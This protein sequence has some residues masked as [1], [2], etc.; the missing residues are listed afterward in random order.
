MESKKVVVTGG[1]GFIGSN[2]VKELLERGFEVHMVDNFMGGR[3]EERINPAAVLHEVDIR[4]TDAL[5][6]IFAGAAYI[7]HLAALPRV[8]ESIDDPIPVHDVNVNGTLSVLEAA[9]DAGVQKVVFSSSAAVYGDHEEMPLHE[10]LPARPKS[11]YGLHKY[12]GEHYAKLWSFL[13]DLPTVSLRY[14]NVYG[15]NF[16]PHGAYALVV[17][18]F[19]DLKR[20]GKPLTIAGDGTN[21]RDYVHVSDIVRANILAAE[22]ELVRNGE[23]MNIGGGVETSVKEIADIIGGPIEHMPPRIEPVRCV[24]NSSKAKDLIGWEPKVSLEDG[25]AG[26]L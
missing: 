11:P 14:F 15:P 17:G 9:R 4:D 13:Y 22:S 5:K 19:I 24:A 12:V 23:V 18:K 20:Q 6:E 21:T 1:V 3:M 25:I 26:L 8:Q 2:L 16:D 10:E 7:F